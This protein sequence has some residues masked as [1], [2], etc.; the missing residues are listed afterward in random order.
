MG[1]Q[2]RLADGVDQYEPLTTVGPAGLSR[3]SRWPTSS[4]AADG[5][6]G[7]RD[8][9]RRTQM[10][11]R[12]EC[13]DAV[14]TSITSSWPYRSACSRRGAENSIADRPEWREMTT[15][16]RTVATQAFQLWL[17]PDESALGWDRPGVTTSAYVAARSRPGRRCRR[18]CGPRT[19][20]TTT[21]PGRSRTSAAA[22]DARRGRPA[23]T[24]A[25]YV[26]DVDNG[27]IA[28]AA[29]YLDRQ[30]GCSFPH[31]VDRQT[32]SPGICSAART[33][34]GAPPRWQPSTSA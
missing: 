23:T 18:R 17:R 11:S 24:R 2:V 3:T 7:S 31:A 34:T 1:R 21:G 19:G 32:A 6:D 10:T 20:P 14:S 16:L 13:C 27:C 5:L 12:R 8:A 4:S 26:A 30:S 28:E 33:A 22:F 9:L 25:T 29:N 15:H